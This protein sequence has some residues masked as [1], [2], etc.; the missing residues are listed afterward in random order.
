MTGGGIIVYNYTIDRTVNFCYDS[1]TDQSV[2]NIFK[3]GI[4]FEAG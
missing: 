1:E 3:G 4:S 2:N